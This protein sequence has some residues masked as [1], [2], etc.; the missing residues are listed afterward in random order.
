MEVVVDT[1]A[2]SA[3]L[4]GDPGIAKPLTEVTALLL[5]PVA[6]GE[7]R[8]GIQASR[9]QASYE[10][11]LQQLEKRFSVLGL[12][13]ATAVAYAEIRRQLKADGRLIP[14]HDV[15]IAAQAKQHKAHI[16]SN[17]GH[18]DFV[19]GVDRIGW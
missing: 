17:D 13:A 15:W 5:S 2:L 18:F 16:L 6:L 19:K 12:D 10:V 14:W 9:E 4:D 3:W 8:F 1:N 7:Y 11:K